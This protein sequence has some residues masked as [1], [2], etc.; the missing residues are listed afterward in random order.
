MQGRRG[1]GCGE[2]LAGP[3]G[4]RPSHNGDVPSSTAASSSPAVRAD[5]AIAG[6]APGYFALVMGTGIVSVGL[7]TAG[8]DGAALVLL[9][10]A[11]VAAAVLV[12]LYMLRG[13]RHPARMRADAR[14]PETA[15]GYFTVVAAASV[16]GVG[17]HDVGLGTAS[18]VLLGIGAALWVVLGYV[19]PW[20]VLMTRDG[21]PI[22]ARTNGSW[23]IWS[24]ASQSLAVG[25]SGLRPATPAFADL[26]GVLTV[27]FWSVGTILYAGIAVL[28]ILRIVHFGITPQQFEPT[29]WV[30][31][32]ALAI[33]VVAGAGIY[34]M[35]SVPMVDAARGLIGGTVVI[36]WCFALWQLPL[37]AGAG[38]WRHLIHRV[39]LR[40]VPSLWS[41]VFPLGMF[42]VASMRLGRVEHLP[43]VEIV[44]DVVLVVAVL[45]WAAV[46][47]G[48]VLTLV[49]GLRGA[50]ATA[51]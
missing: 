31:M 51:G 32:G 1:K 5:Q 33:A 25:L 45:A 30:A 2:C 14:N 6:L 28:V 44:G 27:L 18:V 29:Y 24:V 26:L 47:V 20:Q 15:F 3:A 49:R 11:A 38:L 19:L 42:A 50:R 8:Y 48:L 13:L 43:M 46:A 7:R 16:L 17:M 41:I 10:L 34:A 22:L 40:Y 12:V 35:D 9:V 23:F 21:E 39:P 36:F 37:L 4:A